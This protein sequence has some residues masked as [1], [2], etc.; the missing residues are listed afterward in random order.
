MLF[1]V[2][3]PYSPGVFIF[4]AGYSPEEALLLADPGVDSQARG[5]LH[6]VLMTISKIVKTKTQQTHNKQ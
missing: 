5:T 3:F 2:Y 1:H 4:T 6:P